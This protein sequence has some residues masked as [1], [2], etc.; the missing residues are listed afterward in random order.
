MY[1][2]SY[3]THLTQWIGGDDIMHEL[4]RESTTQLY[5]PDIGSLGVGES[6]EQEYHRQA[7]I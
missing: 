3:E 1:D 7:V 4:Y 5:K 6:G 2:E